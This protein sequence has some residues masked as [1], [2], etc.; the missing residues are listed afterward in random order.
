MFPCF[1][2][3]S[4]SLPYRLVLGYQDGGREVFF[5]MLVGSNWVPGKAPCRCSS[6]LGFLAIV[7]ADETRLRGAEFTTTS[8]EEP[9]SCK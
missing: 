6:A 5:R 7:G 4:S 1:A 8:R 2:L 9:E 3:A